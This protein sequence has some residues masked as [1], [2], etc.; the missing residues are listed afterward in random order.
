MEMRSAHQ[1]NTFKTHETTSRS[2]IISSQQ[3]DPQNAE[4]QNYC[5]QPDHLDNEWQGE[6]PAEHQS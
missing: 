4:V 3:S 2:I 5:G 1:E 6:Q